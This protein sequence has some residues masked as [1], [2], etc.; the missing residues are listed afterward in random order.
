MKWSDII[1]CN[2]L[3]PYQVNEICKI[4]LLG[5]VGNEKIAKKYG[6]SNHVINRIYNMVIAYY[7][8]KKK[9][10]NKPSETVS[11]RGWTHRNYETENDILKELNLDYSNVVLKG[12]E[13]E[14]YNDL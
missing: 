4:I 10:R 8:Q 7:S 3:Q 12:E 14:I 11:F 13:L 6:V 9:D 1:E 5:K 2:V